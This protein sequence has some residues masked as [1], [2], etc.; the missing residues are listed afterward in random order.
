MATAQH[1]AL[2]DGRIDRSSS[3]QAQ[4]SALRCLRRK[5]VTD[6]SHNQTSPSRTRH[7]LA[8]RATTPRPTTRRRKIARHL[9]PRQVC[10]SRPTRDESGPP[11][12]SCHSFV[13]AADSL[14]RTPDQARTPSF[15]QPP[16]HERRGLTHHHGRQAWRPCTSYPDPRD[17]G[18]KLTTRRLCFCW[19]LRRHREWVCIQ[20]I[21]A[22][23]AS[24][25]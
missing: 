18:C 1:C 24:R 11:F 17:R 10:H 15:R 14:Y 7:R 5:Y 19:N 12:G 20:T 13:Q 25:T 23:S 9:P 8:K 22:T 4:P 16:L 21:P 2:S 3:G 6:R